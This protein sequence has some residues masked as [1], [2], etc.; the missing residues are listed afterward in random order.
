[1]QLK[2]DVDRKLATTSD[3]PN[4]RLLIAEKQR[5]DERLGACQEED[6]GI[7]AEI[8]LK[9]SELA[10]RR[11]QIEDR[12]RDRDAATEGKRV[13]RLARRAQQAL[14]E[15]I[16][17]LH[18]EKLRSLETHFNLMYGKL[19]KPEDP[20]ASITV[21]RTTW[22]VVLRDHKARPLERRV[23]SAGMKEMFALSLLWAL[24]RASGRDLPIVIDTPLGRLDS[25]NR[26]ALCE[27]YF[28]SAGH[29]VVVL[30]TDKEVD[31]EWFGVLKPHVSSQYRLDFDSKT[32]ST[33]IRPGYFF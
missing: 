27:H 18:P 11:R 29:Q 22:E 15:F 30:S 28:P 7:H 31:Q 19:Q 16:R 24:S 17:R 8:E 2:E 26:A 9:R 4:V 5:V 12:Q 6:R 21:D 10:A 1:M 14:D 33:I 32:D 25:K 3:D 20:V 13:V 23:F